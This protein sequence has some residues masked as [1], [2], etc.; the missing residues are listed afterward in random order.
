MSKIIEIG[1]NEIDSLFDNN[2]NITLL[3]KGYYDAEIKFKPD[4]PLILQKCVLIM[5]E[6]KKSRIIPL[7]NR[8]DIDPCT[9]DKIFTIKDKVTMRHWLSE[10][11]K[12]IVSKNLQADITELDNILMQLKD[13]PKLALYGEAIK[14]GASLVKLM[15]LSKAYYEKYVNL[16]GK[17]RTKSVV[18]SNLKLAAG[19]FMFGTSA[20][21][22]LWFA[23]P[24]ATCSIAAASM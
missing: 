21:S 17:A 2:R 15:L 24:E 4:V 1:I 18:F 19:W 7:I 16:N 14:C 6:C 11:K 3:P 12:Y 9:G 23:L 10:K 13:K 8:F 22:G 20:V 5:S